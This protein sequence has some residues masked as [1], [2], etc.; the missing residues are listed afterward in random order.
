MA[1]KQVME[2]RWDP[3][4]REWVLVSNIRRFRPWQPTNYCPFC[5]GGPETGYGWRALIL[6]NKYPMLM[7]NPPE[8]SNHWFYLTAKSVGRCYVVVET[9]EHNIDDL[10]DL[11]TDQIEYVLRMIINKAREES[12]KDYAYYFLWFRNK[13][14]EIGVS[15]THPHSQIYVLPFIPSRVEREIESAREY[16]AKNGKCL[17]CDVINAEVRDGVRIIY[18]NEH[19]VS[20]M[21]FYSH[22]PFEVHIYPRRHVQL[23]MELTDEEVRS[24]ALALKVSLC[25][26]THLFRSKSMPYI[27]V[28]HQA[29]LKGSYPFYHLH[30]EIYGILREEDKMKYAAGMEVGGGNF[31]YD[32][33]PEENAQRLRDSVL[34]NCV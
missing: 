19:W 30:I 4:L 21:P 25:G 1:D 20:F 8:P 5:P 6:E 14:R 17:F 34:R 10:S 28:L 9:P 31:T 33:V 24:L 13:G 12:G 11:P 3:I 22:W 27:L 26:L 15:L 16:F 29:P 18:E 7:E 23:I 2:L 32:A